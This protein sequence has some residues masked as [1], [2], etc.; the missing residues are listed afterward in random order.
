MASFL[1]NILN[2]IKKTI[3]DPLGIISGITSKGVTEE[4]DPIDNYQRYVDALNLEEATKRGDAFKGFT[5]PP[6]TQDLYNAMLNGVSPDE[7]IIDWA[8]KAGTADAAA[9]SSDP[10]YQMQGI[11]DRMLNGAYPTFTAQATA[12]PSVDKTL[13]TPPVID[14]S[15]MATGTNMATSAYNTAM[16]ALSGIPDTYKNSVGYLQSVPNS[17]NLANNMISNV[18]QSGQMG[19][20][21]LNAVPG[22]YNTSMDFLSNVNVQGQQANQFLG[23]V[24]TAGDAA[25][26]AIAQANQAAQ[27]AY[28]ELAQV[29]PAA[30]QAY[31]QIDQANR[32]AGVGMDY[33]AQ[34]QNSY[35]RANEALDLA[36]EA[37]Y[38]QEHAL[39]LSQA[40]AEGN[41]PSAA[42][43]LMK[44]GLQTAQKN[45]LATAASA[46]GG[47]GAE[48][49]A[50]N[51]AIGQNAELAQDVAVQQAALRAQEMAVARGEYNAASQ[52]LRAGDIAQAQ[53]NVNAGGLLTNAGQVAANL[54]QVYNTGGQVAVGIGNMY[55]NAANAATNI[56]NMYNNS[57]Q[58]AVGIGNMYTGAANASA[59]VGNM[60]TG[61]A[62]AA[63]NAGGLL[64]AGANAATSQGNMYTNAGNA[65][66]NAGNMMTGASLANTAA[67]NMMIGSSN[68]AT[69]A[70]GIGINLSDQARQ[71]A[72][73][74]AINQLNANK[75]YAD[76]VYNTN[77]L[78]ATLGTDI[79]KF[80][81]GQQTGAYNEAMN[82]AVQTIMNRA[83]ISESDRDA[84][85]AAAE[86]RARAMGITTGYTQTE[87]AAAT[88]KQAGWIQSLGTL[89][90]GATGSTDIKPV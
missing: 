10:Y 66:V 35:D 57:G 20:N 49:I 48:M 11:T 23:Q 81:A 77:A 25:Y 61:A 24:S 56:G 69:N 68:A 16:G 36:S 7:F 50:R 82:K 70:A 67:G 4:T 3:G 85:L 72:T 14:T 79:N 87:R 15:G 44:A 46:R 32:A 90:G 27:Y 33:L 26:Q 88:K 80:N 8:M 78:T 34:V 5:P 12:M 55:T 43:M 28:Q 21:F 60:Y 63:T 13:Y 51:A 76:A 18:N 1:E 89:F 54:G 39:S 22:A 59:N 19:T 71:V 29:D 73:Q 41:A 45:A 74:N 84:E 42:E 52:Q 58:V 38:A 83:A 53:G 47:I 17:Y 62:N 9:M 75:A 31:A 30:A 40:A 64:V 37:R 2:P 86:L 65:Y 6:T